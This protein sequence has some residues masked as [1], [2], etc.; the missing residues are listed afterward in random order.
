MSIINTTNTF[1]RYLS[2]PSAYTPPQDH[3]SQK[4]N[5]ERLEFLDKLKRHTQDNSHSRE[6]SLEGTF[7]SLESGSS[8]EETLQPAR[9]MLRNMVEKASFK[10][11]LMKLR[12]SE[13][14]LFEVT[15]KGQ[16]KAHYAGRT[17]SFEGAFKLAP[18]LNDDLVVLV[19][20][21]Q[22][23]GGIVT[24]DD[25]VGMI[26]W[27]RFHR[28]LLPRT[29]IDA[30]NLIAFLEQRHPVSPPFGNYWE[31]IQVE[32]NNPLT[33]SSAQRNRLRALIKEHTKGESLLELLSETVLGGR[34]T[35]FKR[36]DAEHFLKTLVSSS[37]ALI[38][39]KS[40]VRDLDWYGAQEDQPLSDES[41]QQILL[42][43][44]LLDLHPM[45]GEQEP[46]NQVAGFDL[47][48][49]Q[50]IEKSFDSVQTEFER[51]LIN[52]HRITEQNAALASHLLLA[53]TA[54]EFLVKD[55]P[56]TLLLGT[57]QWVDYCRTIAVQET[58]SPG[59]SHS[60]TH[61][62]I[63]HLMKSD[64]VTESQQALNALAA[65]DPVIDWAL[66]N[67]IVTHDEVNRSAKD[68]LEVA[69]AAYAR[70]AKT[71]AETAETL[72]R[73]LPTRKSVALDILK[74][75]AKGCTYL[76]DDVLHQKSNR[77]LEDAYANPFLMSPV[78]LHMSNDLQTGDWGLK[79]G[80]SIYTA[81]PKMLPNL[82]SPDGV[83]YRQFNQNYVS[84]A[85]AVSTHLKLALSSLPLVDRARLLR[86]QVTIFSVRPSVATLHPITRLP[87]NPLASTLDVILKVPN[88]VPMES[89]KDKEQAT[90]RYGVVMCTYF[91]GRLSCYELFTLHGVCRENTELAELI[92]RENLL[93]TSPRG[94]E[95]NHTHP[96]PVHQLP[97]D[98]EC[99][100]HGV[101][102]GLVNTSRGVIE[103]IG[104]L[105]APPLASDIESKGYYQSFYSS[106][107]ESLVNFVLKHRPIATYDELV[108][109]CWGQTRLEALRAEREEG[110][111]TFLNIVVPF[112]SCIEDISSDDLDRQFQGVGACT[113]EAAMTLLLVVGVIA[114]V[115]SLAVRSMTLATKASAMAKT[116]LGLAS[117]LLN[118]LD[119]VT[120]LLIGGAKLLRKGFNGS[121][122]VL[123]NAISDLRQLTGQT[124]FEPLARA[125]DPDIIRL[126]T[127]RPVESSK[128]LF[129]VWGIRQNDHWYALNRHG[130]PWG[131]KL[132]NFEPTKVWHLLK[133]DK[134]MP[135]SYTRKLLNDALPASRTK[136]DDA[137][138]VL[139]DAS[140][141]TDSGKV[142]NLLLGD[143]SSQGRGK[144]LTHLNE[145]KND[146]AKVTPDNFIL[147]TAQ[148][149]SI[150]SLNPIW[151]K[152]WV[153]ATPKDA[154][155][156]KFMRIYSHNFNQ[157][158]RTEGYSH[159]VLAD[160]IVHEL[161]HGAPDTKDLS[162]AGLPKSG[163]LGNYQRLD[164][165]PLIN[166]ASGHGRDR[167]TQKVIDKAGA[168]NNADSFALTTSLLS[169]LSKDPVM[170]RRNIETMSKALE[171]NNGYIGW[172]VLVELNPV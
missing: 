91:E 4:D 120:D 145:V 78:D 110:L 43:A 65:V 81:F 114:K 156:Q 130:Q 18:D 167:V 152:K 15:A 149:D 155:Q 30:Q 136:I 95:K 40:F 162:Y 151:Y 93:H 34:S 169:Q 29:V 138:K 26:Q 106:E 125:V 105:S 124:Q 84:H 166:L 64:S 56:P 101:T 139:T 68:S 99:Y 59:S 88:R 126:G 131:A 144:L 13:D 3:N 21:A 113:L 61:A 19:E 5:I 28:Y 140:L 38:W 117:S 2:R 51:H 129:R 153:G 44:L 52:H 85:Q 90:G 161:F 128:D 107:F 94:S 1:Q 77:P 96:A 58:L 102:P 134:L 118:P 109:E 57:P 74:Q 103:K 87:M 108:K 73:P 54:P 165:A 150:A 100:T 14:S 48:A 62:Q 41:L 33:V 10:N 170:Y 98:I 158:F 67:S 111:N 76:E 92:E 47:Y 55:L 79:H 146:I 8:L 122:A 157:Q 24:L 82:I 27:L 69:V 127:W 9:V 97:T 141:D 121:V 46:R 42:T 119:G 116:G 163:R 53:G 60:M 72:S 115:A 37:I 39:A 7:I 159:N 49:A 135:A 164:V 75:V 6:V 154:A 20:M 104:E 32:E 86:G 148:S 12:L 71:I 17:Q 147:D 11:L 25:Q 80:A 31:M 143:N 22:L 89:H 160:D 172:E 132:N 83:F 137:I 16:V 63:Q 36:S 171:R 142:V 70:H 35:P 45:V 112:K 123:E 50:H 168:F 23:T 133:L 66:L